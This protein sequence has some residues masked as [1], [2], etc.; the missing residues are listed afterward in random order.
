MTLHRLILVAIPVL[1][2]CQ[3]VKTTVSVR[4]TPP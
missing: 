1:A 4:G 2:F 3:G